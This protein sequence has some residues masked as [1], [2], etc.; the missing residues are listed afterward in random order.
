MREEFLKNDGFQNSRF[1]SPVEFEISDYDNAVKNSPYPQTMEKETE[2]TPE[3]LPATQ[4]ETT[5]QNPQVKQEPMEQTPKPSSTKGQREIRNLE[6]GLNGKAWECTETHRP[7]LRV[8]TTGIKEEE[9]YMGSWDN[10]IPAKEE[11]QQQQD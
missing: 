4:P 10:T 9:E 8:K 6:S 2:V 11:T 1:E 3:P 7:R 5:Q